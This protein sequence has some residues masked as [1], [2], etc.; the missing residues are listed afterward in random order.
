M[1]S[2][3]PVS[4]Q[5]LRLP[6]AKLALPHPFAARIVLILE[7]A[8]GVVG[9]RVSERI[10]RRHGGLLTLHCVAAGVSAE[11]GVLAHPFRG[12]RERVAQREVPAAAAI[13]EWRG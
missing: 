10:S 6:G 7:L 3:R 4:T 13:G 5:W 8:S 11:L 9:E 1:A 12:G 2:V